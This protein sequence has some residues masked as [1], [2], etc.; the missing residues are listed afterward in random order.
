MMNPGR[1]KR[2]KRRGLAAIELALMLPI[3]VAIGLISADYAMMFDRY[4]ALSDLARGVA[5]H[6]AA[7][8]SATVDDL[9]QVLLHLN[10]PSSTAT[11]TLKL[12]SDSTGA[13]VEVDVTDK[14]ESLLGAPTPT[15][16]TMVRSLVMMRNP[17]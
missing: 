12:T 5:V 6:Y 1:R 8:P 2:T 14:Y 15:N 7:N 10:S 13:Y 17:L 4:S 9:P 11:A 3:L 16:V